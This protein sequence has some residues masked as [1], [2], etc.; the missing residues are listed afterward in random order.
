MYGPSEGMWVE[1]GGREG[2]GD[3]ELCK[4]ESDFRI[5]GK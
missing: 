5:R 4:I 1:R 2:E 3:P